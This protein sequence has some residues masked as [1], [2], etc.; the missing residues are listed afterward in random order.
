MLRADFTNAV[1]DDAS[2]K[3]ADLRMARFY[4][5]RLRRV[6]LTGAKLDGADMLRA[7]FSGATWT[8]GATVCAEGSI[9]RCI[10]TGTG[11]KIDDG[12]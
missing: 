1:L 2:L 8:D 9:G 7:D 10:G 5:A 6:D 11:A 3:D 12:I 4:D